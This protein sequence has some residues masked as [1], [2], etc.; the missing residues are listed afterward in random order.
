MFDKQ[1]KERVRV[2]EGHVEALKGNAAS[3]AA[4]RD[5]LESQVDKLL[6]QLSEVTDAHRSLLDAHREQA[7][8]LERVRT[9]QPVS[10]PMQG[11]VP[12]W[13]PEAEEDARFQLENGLIDKQL[14][15][16]IL[17][18]IGLEPNTEVHLT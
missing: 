13:M 9:V 1:L 6:K 18:E 16:E 5:V 11:N 4:V 17:E 8:V 10:V 3:T 12:L 7:E 2:L 14:Y 15:N